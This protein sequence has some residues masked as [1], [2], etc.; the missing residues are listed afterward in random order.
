MNQKTG[1][2]QSGGVNIRGTVGS[3]GGDIVGRDKIT[4]APSKTDLD[5]ALR[6]LA[7]AISTAAPEKR[8]EAEQK[9]E[10]LKQEAS[11]GKAANDT[12]LAKLVEGLV[13]LVPSGAGAVLSAF[14]TPVLGAIAG[15]IT[16]Y[17]LDKLQ[18]K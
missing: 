6:E 2:G 11:K 12:V 8:V 15:P 5:G 14:G 13:A 9:L 16:K 3:V 10:A 1:E 7:A 4:G 18:G 17:V